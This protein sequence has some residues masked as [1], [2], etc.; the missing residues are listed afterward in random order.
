MPLRTFTTSRVECQPE[1]ANPIHREAHGLIGNEIF[2]VIEQPNPPGLPRNGLVE[3][4]SGV[5]AYGPP[6]REPAP[7]GALERN[8]TRTVDRRFA[9]ISTDIESVPEFR[10]GSVVVLS[11]VGSMIFVSKFERQEIGDTAMW[12][13][14]ARLVGR[15]PRVCRYARIEVQLIPW[16][17][18]AT[19]LRITPRSRCVHLWGVRR[20]RRYW[21]LAHRAASVLKEILLAGGFIANHCPDQDHFSPNHP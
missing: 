3:A 14:L 8:V 21:L 5:F 17:A 19:E 11:G 12:H 4:S 18:T 9:A 16:S 1:A 6:P 2:E 20:R 10:A 7:S 13:A 15:G